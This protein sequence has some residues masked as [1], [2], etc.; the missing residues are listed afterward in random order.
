MQFISA[1]IFGASLHADGVRQTDVTYYI[2]HVQY[3]MITKVAR[4]QEISE[5]HASAAGTF[6]KGT[7]YALYRASIGTAPVCDCVGSCRASFL[8]RC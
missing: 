5:T 8:L 4:G 6:S 3:V 1:D 7:V 2:V